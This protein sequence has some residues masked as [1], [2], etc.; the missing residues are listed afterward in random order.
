MILLDAPQFFFCGNLWRRL[1]PGTL[2]NCVPVTF[3]LFLKEKTK[4]NKT[5]RKEK[6]LSSDEWS[7]LLRS[8]KIPISVE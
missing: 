7:W 2:R 6:K 5:K 4:Q 1:H 8:I 3:N